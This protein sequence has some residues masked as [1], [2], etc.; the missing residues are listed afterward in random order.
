MSAS[1]LP[2]QPVLRPRAAHLGPERRRPLILDVALELFVERG[3]KGTSMEAVASAAGVTKPV[4][5]DCFASKAELFGALLDREE[6]RM[7][8]QFSAA[9]TLGERSEDLRSTLVAGFTSMLR[10]VTDTPQTYRIALLGDSDATAVIE[11]RVQ[12]GKERR[13]SAIAEIARTWLSEQEVA[14]DRLDAIAEFAGQTLVGLGEAGMRMMLATPNQW[15]PETLGCAL[16]ELAAGG[17]SSIA[18]TN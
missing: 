13:I 12:H 11:A 16:G 15:S 9:L 3:Y 17:Y 1:S 18:W 8:A 10:A 7:L 6:Q 4:V 14:A 5:Y 2:R